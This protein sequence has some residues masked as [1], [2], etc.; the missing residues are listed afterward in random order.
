MKLSI[1]KISTLLLVLFVV[2]SNAQMTNLGQMFTSQ[3][4]DVSVLQNFVNK[5]TATVINNG[6]LYLDKDFNN[7]GIVTFTN[8][9]SAKTIFKGIENQK[10]IGDGITEFFNLKVDNNS[11]KTSIKLNKEIGVYGEANFQEGIIERL[12]KGKAVF[13]PGA[14]HNNLNDDSYIDNKVFKEGNE[15]FIFP[16][17]HNNLGEF[18][19]RYT[20]ISAPNNSKDVFSA[21]YIWENS[22]SKFKHLN[23]EYDEDAETLLLDERKIEEIPIEICNCFPFVCMLFKCL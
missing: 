17:G 15:A 14:F 19:T 11:K 7:N 9:E 13:K 18:I 2:R 8:D 21:E 4:T 5:D 3:N 1:K 20:S 6:N 23:K 10:I 12:S 16:V 22:D